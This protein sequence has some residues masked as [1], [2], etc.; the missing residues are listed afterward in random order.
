MNPSKLEVGHDSVARSVPPAIERL[1]LAAGT[2]PRFRIR[3][4]QMNQ[5]KRGVAS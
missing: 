2:C 1:C 5:R 3:K 4:L